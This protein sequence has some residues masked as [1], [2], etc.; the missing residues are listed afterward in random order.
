MALLNVNEVMKILRCKQTKAYEIIKKLNQ[1]LEKQGY[2]TI[3]GKVE[4]QYLKERFR[5]NS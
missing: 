3:K 1:D 4:E 2:Y 5:I